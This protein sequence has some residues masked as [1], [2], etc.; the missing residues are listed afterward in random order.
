MDL[1]YIIKESFQR[2]VE[3]FPDFYGNNL[4]ALWDCLWGFIETPV[5]IVVT[6]FENLDKDLKEEVSEINRVF[7]DAAK[8]DWG[9]YFRTE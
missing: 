4:N 9:I 5:E 3:G 6:G 2:S 1:H 7:R 8:E